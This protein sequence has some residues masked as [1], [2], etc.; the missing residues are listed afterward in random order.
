VVAREGTSTAYPT[1]YLA[2][3]RAT[4]SDPPT[5]DPKYFSTSVDRLSMHTSLR[6]ISRLMLSTSSGQET[7][8]KECVPPRFTALLLDAQG[9]QQAGHLAGRFGWPVRLGL[10][11]DQPGRG[12]GVSG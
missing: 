4:P 11:A 12:G 8:G 2:K 1:L 5:V 7:I 10:V 6:T 3:V 9:T